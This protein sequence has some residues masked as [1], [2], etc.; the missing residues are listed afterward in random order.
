MCADYSKAYFFMGGTLDP[1]YH[2][3]IPRATHA[4]VVVTVLNC[5]NLKSRLK[6]VITRNLNPQVVVEFNGRQQ[7][8][9]VINNSSSPVFSQGGGGCDQHHNPFVFEIPETLDERDPN[10]CVKFLVDD[11][12]GFGLIADRLSAVRIPLAA[13]RCLASTEPP[14]K[15]VIPLEMRRRHFGIREI[16]GIK[17]R[18]DNVRVSRPDDANLKVG[19]ASSES[20]SL[21]VLISKTDDLKLW[22]LRELQVRDE[23]WE[24]DVVAE[25]EA[26]R[27]RSCSEEALRALQSKESPSSYSNHRKPAADETSYASLFPFFLWSLPKEKYDVNKT[28]EN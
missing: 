16:V 20:I 12:H 24:A 15:M 26:Q 13:I 27:Q 19:S 7:K 18:D 23:I 10:S 6:R 22:L 14:T 25:R 21:T 8:T 9:V 28:E 5:K 17:S 11:I 1:P 3:P 2:M 4:T